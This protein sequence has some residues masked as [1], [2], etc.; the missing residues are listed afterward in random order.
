LFEERRK[1][2]MNYR[3]THCDRKDDPRAVGRIG[4]KRLEAEMCTDCM[5]FCY[6]V[7]G[8]MD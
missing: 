8:M 1:E 6:P 3:G 4:L 7:V 5:D 2:A